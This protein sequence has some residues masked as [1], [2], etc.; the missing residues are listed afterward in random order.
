MH[1][2]LL[3]G[4]T[5]EI[6]RRGPALAL[7]AVLVLVGLGGL[8]QALA[9][10]GIV[11]EVEPRSL[12]SA[13]F[14]QHGE[15]TDVDGVLGQYRD[16]LSFVL[17]IGSQ[18]DPRGAARLRQT[19]AKLVKRDPALAAR[20]LRGLRFEL[21]QKLE[22]LGFPPATVTARQPVIRKWVTRF[23]PAWHREADE[24]LFRSVA[25]SGR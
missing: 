8:W 9:P 10:T 16:Y 21:I 6:A 13:S 2:G 14:P 19:Y 20:F 17:E 23:L 18:T 12:S 11:G 3:A 25:I 7:V 22:M 5:S 24:Y 1:R 4:E 15:A